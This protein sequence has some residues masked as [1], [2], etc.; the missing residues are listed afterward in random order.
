M[1]TAGG[2][3]S[4][5][6]D[7]HA[8]GNPGHPLLTPRYVAYSPGSSSN[9]FETNPLLLQPLMP[10]GFTLGLTW[11]S[12]PLSLSLSLYIYIYMYGLCYIP[13]TTPVE[14]LHR[15][16][17]FTEARCK[18]RIKAPN[19]LVDLYR[20]GSLPCDFISKDFTIRSMAP[21][22][23]VTPWIFSQSSILGGGIVE[24]W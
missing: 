4:R 18:N 17:Y 16:Q 13:P 3:E 11:L 19:S 12:L 7:L 23:F 2:P 1:A 8:R 21:E 15:R 9:A 14:S 5:L 20:H 24:L 10:P 6:A 22:V